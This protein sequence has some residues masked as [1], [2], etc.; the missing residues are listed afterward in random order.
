MSVQLRP[1]QQHLVSA[2][3]AEW[4]RGT[5]RVMAQLPTGGGKTV[6][7][8]SI[9]HSAVSRG[10]RCM[11]IVHRKELI[12]QAGQKLFRMGV[13]YGVVMAGHESYYSRPVQ[14]ASVQTLV[15]RTMPK[16]IDILIT[17]ECHHATAD[18]YR[19]IYDNYPNARF[20]GVTATPC[21]ANGAGFNDLY[22][23]LVCGPDVPELISGGYLVEPK[24]FISPIRVDLSRIRTVA[25]D[26]STDALAQAI[27]TP[28]LV[29]DLPAN[30]SRIAHGKRTVVFA[31]NVAHSNHIVEQYRSAGVS[32]E[33]IDGTT[34]QD[35]RD[36][37]LRKFA[38]GQITVL[39]NVG[40]VTEGFDVPEIECVQLARPTKSLSLYLQMVGRGLRPAQGKSSAIILDHSDCI[41]T[42]GFPQRPRE[43][44]LMGAPKRTGGS[45]HSVMVRDTQGRLRFV[46]ELPSVADCTLVE[47]SYSEHRIGLL[48]ESVELSRRYSQKPAAGWYKFVD[49]HC[50]SEKPTEYEIEQFR[51]ISPEWDKKSIFIAHLLAQYGYPVPDAFKWITK[52]RL[53]A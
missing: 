4:Q 28:V 32:A 23:A 13:N 43:W 44:S 33:H 21:R 2:I 26:Y 41:V 1:Y 25:G 18:S 34:P 12:S 42:H 10:E 27:D 50:K 17:D 11:M 8:N 40:I 14:L 49:R 16:N 22:D 53:T 9:I 36:R 29:G 3:H 51:R 15:R 35:Q 7:F 39:S 46:H 45:E 24:L 48:T 31:I 38:D 20:L 52:Q 47:V 30:W 5:R 37:I 6:I 19:K